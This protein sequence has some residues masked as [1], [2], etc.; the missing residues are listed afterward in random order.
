M[1]RANHGE[2]VDK[3]LA[4]HG[5]PPASEDD[6]DTG[7]GTPGDMISDGVLGWAESKGAQQI[8]VALGHPIA[9]LASALGP[10]PAEAIEQ[11]HSQGIKVAALIGRVQ[12]AG[13]DLQRGVDIII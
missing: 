3:T 7:A 2:Y 10:P 4:D 6:V 13:R 11:A 8:D 5:V 12:Q 9:L 1:I